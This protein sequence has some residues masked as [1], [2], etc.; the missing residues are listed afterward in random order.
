MQDQKLDDILWMLGKDFNALAEELWHS[1]EE[2][3]EVVNAVTGNQ[4]KVTKLL[5]SDWDRDE[6]VALTNWYAILESLEAKY[7]VEIAELNISPNST[8]DF[9]FWVLQLDSLSTLPFVWDFLFDKIW[10]EK[11]ICTKNLE[12]EWDKIIGKSKLIWTT[13]W[14]DFEISKI[15]WEWKIKTIDPNALK[16]VTYM[17]WD[18][19]RS[20]LESKYWTEIISSEILRWANWIIC[21]K[22]TLIS[23][24]QCS[25]PFIWTKITFSFS[26][27]SVKDVRNMTFWQFSSYLKWEVLLPDW[28]WYSFEWDNLIWKTDS[29]AIWFYKDWNIL[30]EV[31]ENKH[32]INIIDSEFQLANWHNGNLYWTVKTDKWFKF[33]FFWDK[34][35]HVF[36]QGNVTDV[37]KISTNWLTWNLHG[38]VRIDHWY[39]YEFSEESL[40]DRIKTYSDWNDISSTIEKS[41]G[42]MVIWCKEQYIQ[43]DWVMCWILTTWT[44]CCLPFQWNRLISEIDWRYIKDAID[45]ITLSDW[46]LT[47]IVQLKDNLWY[48]FEWDTIK[49][50]APL[51]KDSNSYL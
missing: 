24:P 46:R 9:T 8:N 7:S 4:N 42:I 41:Y 33:P 43:S 50:Y 14:S 1:P 28:D 31:L 35:Y 37:R 29:A 27:S 5:E 36:P 45:L 40:W 51:H 10:N 19:L 3:R 26:G 34:L 49:W 47:W 25:V 20:Q 38:E 15:N 12:I 23:S 13:I 2:A 11:I 16:A 39:W 22:V 44:W 6:A 21:W 48:E 32:K 18:D 30:K 17:D